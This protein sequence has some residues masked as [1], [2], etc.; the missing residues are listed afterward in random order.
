M[1]LTRT[2]DNLSKLRDRNFR[3]QRQTSS[4]ITKIERK[5][6]SRGIANL[7]GSVSIFAAQTLGLCTICRYRPTVC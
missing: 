5:N 4:R 6:P 3:R 1:S 2:I 7:V